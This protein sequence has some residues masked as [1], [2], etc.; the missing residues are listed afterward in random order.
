MIGVSQ[1]ETVDP[2]FVLFDTLQQSVPLTL[3]ELILSDVHSTDSRTTCNWLIEEILT[4]DTLN[5]M[6]L[7]VKQ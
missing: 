4:K 1:Q 6:R 2:D 3:K 7:I 5:E